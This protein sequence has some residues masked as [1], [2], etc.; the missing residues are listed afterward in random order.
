M[1]DLRSYLE[2]MNRSRSRVSSVEEVGAGLFC[3]LY[4]WLERVLPVER[5]I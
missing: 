1:K 5:I 2:R 3:G 4:F